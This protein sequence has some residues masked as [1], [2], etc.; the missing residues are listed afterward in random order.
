MDHVLIVVFPSRVLTI[1]VTFFKSA[2][3]KATR[4]VGI[5]GVIKNIC[6][7]LLCSPSVISTWNISGMLLRATTLRGVVRFTANCACQKKTKQYNK[8]KSNVESR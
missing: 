8:V 4:Y 7:V 5:T 6:F 2:I 3:A 1:V